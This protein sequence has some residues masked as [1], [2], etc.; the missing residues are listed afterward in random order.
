[1]IFSLKTRKKADYRQSRS[2]WKT[3]L[4]IIY[5]DKFQKKN[6]K[7]SK[8]IRLGYLHLCKMML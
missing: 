6:E 7:I 1:L 2:G 5:P 8:I 4:K 3:F